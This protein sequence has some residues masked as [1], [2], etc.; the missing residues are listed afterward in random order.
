LKRGNKNRKRKA[1]KEPEDKK[2]ALKIDKIPTSKEDDNTEEQDSPPPKVK[3]VMT[4]L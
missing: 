3:K 1:S 2:T 4:L